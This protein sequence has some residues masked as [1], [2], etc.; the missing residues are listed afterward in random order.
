MKLT[1]QLLKYILK[2]LVKWEIKYLKMT[3]NSH[4]F[5]TKCQMYDND[6]YIVYEI[7][8]FWDKM[9][10]DNLDNI[11]ILRI[12]YFWFKWDMGHNTY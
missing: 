7:N 12:I 1:A 4:L 6:W 8:I 11:C 9:N 10:W 2:L 5:L 3:T